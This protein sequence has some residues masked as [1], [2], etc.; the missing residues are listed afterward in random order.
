MASCTT[1]G[2]G[3]KGIC[4]AHVQAVAVFACACVKALCVHVCIAAGP[5]HLENRARLR[6]D[7]PHLV[8]NSLPIMGHVDYGGLEYFLRSIKTHA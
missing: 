8:R 6:H 1:A 4:D 7:V 3:G 2:G 5:V